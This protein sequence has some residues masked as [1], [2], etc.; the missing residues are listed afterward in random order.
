MEKQIAMIGMIYE[1]LHGM[2]SDMEDE[3]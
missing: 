2:D 1:T 3:V